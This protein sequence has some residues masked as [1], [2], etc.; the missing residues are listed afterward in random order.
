MRGETCFSF[1]QSIRWAS[2]GWSRAFIMDLT[3]FRNLAVQDGYQSYAVAYALYYNIWTGVYLYD[4][5]AGAF[6]AV[7]WLMNLDL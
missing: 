2:D 7:T 6:S 4:Y 5:D 1:A 3:N